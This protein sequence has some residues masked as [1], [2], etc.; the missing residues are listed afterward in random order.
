M[1]KCHFTTNTLYHI[2]FNNATGFPKINFKFVN[3]LLNKKHV[4]LIINGNKRQV[5]T[6]V[7]PAAKQVRSYDCLSASYL[8]LQLHLW[9]QT[10]CSSRK[11]I[12][13]VKN[14]LSFSCWNVYTALSPPPSL[15][16]FLKRRVVSQYRKRCRSA[17]RIGKFYHF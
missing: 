11:I 6:L 7:A 10:Q 3:F 2:F 4:F 15:P 16:L 12:D 14:F 1:V 17:L 5:L 8:I 13:N 9:A